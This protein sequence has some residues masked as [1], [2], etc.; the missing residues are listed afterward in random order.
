MTTL[1]AEITRDWERASVQICAVVGREGIALKD[2]PIGCRVARGSVGGAVA[3]VSLSLV[4]L[5][6]DGQCTRCRREGLL[7]SVLLVSS[8]RSPL[9]FVEASH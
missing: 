3:H 4:E 9:L 6:T 7:V 2:D 1:D 8:N 5:E